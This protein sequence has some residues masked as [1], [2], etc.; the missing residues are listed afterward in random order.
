[1]TEGRPRYHMRPS[2][3]LHS[4]RNIGFH[5][6][7][8]RTCVPL[9]GNCGPAFYCTFLA[10][11]VLYEWRT[12]LGRVSIFMHRVANILKVNES[13]AKFM[14]TQIHVSLFNSFIFTAKS[15]FISNT[16]ILFS[17][18]HIVTLHYK[19]CERNCRFSRHLEWI[20]LKWIV[21]Y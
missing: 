13:L 19:N 17:R 20:V 5:G 21:K 14:A 3:S 12:V 7:V 4:Q 10:C 16:K 2:Y 15:N 8:T 9:F 6:N 18:T 11:G 1:V